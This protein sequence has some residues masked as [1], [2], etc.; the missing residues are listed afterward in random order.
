MDEWIVD[1]VNQTVK[2]VEIINGTKGIA[3]QS[4]AGCSELTQLVI[5]ESVEYVGNNAFRACSKLEN[6]VLGT[7]L[8]HIGARAFDV[9]NT[10]SSVEFKDPEKWYVNGLLSTDLYDKSKAAELLSQTAVNY[11]WEK[12]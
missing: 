7:N 6:V 1:I 3:D 10:L 8:K 5:P 9:C 4:F 12:K 11:S 2:T